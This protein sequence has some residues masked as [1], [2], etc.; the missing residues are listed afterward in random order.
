MPSA[1]MHASATTLVAKLTRRASR[2]TGERNCSQ[3]TAGVVLPKMA[4]S[5]RAMN[6]M[7]TAVAK[8]VSAA[9]TTSQKRRAPL[10]DRAAGRDAAGR[11]TSS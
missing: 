10:E 2:A 5:G 11:R 4:K 9:A 6:T 8:P 7:S 3:K 1:T